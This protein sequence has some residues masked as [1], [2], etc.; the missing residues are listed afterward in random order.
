MLQAPADDLGLGPVHERRLH[1]Q[2][3]L[4]AQPHR[5]VGGLDELGPAVRIAGVVVVMHA[6]P[7]H[8]RAEGVLQAGHLGQ[9]QQVARRHVRRGHPGDRR[10]VAPLGQGRVGVGERRTVDGRQLD[11]EVLHAEVRGHLA[12]GLQLDRVLLPVEEGVGLDRLAGVLVLDPGGQRGGVE[13]SAQQQAV[14]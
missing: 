2:L 11:E 7:Q 6:Q 4:R 3:V 9:E 10:Q 8:G 12:G 13:P 14:R 1:P 5:L